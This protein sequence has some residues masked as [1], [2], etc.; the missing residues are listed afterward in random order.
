MKIQFDHDWQ[1]A[2]VYLEDPRVNSATGS[3]RVMRVR[4]EYGVLPNVAMGG[5]HGVLTA[6]DWEKI[7]L[8]GHQAFL[9]A[10][11]LNHTPSFD[12]AVQLITS[13]YGQYLLEK[14]ES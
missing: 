4:D 1:T 10:G 2:T 12:D 13:I 7:T 6:H 5:G 9:V 14:V 11:F 3:F 8:A